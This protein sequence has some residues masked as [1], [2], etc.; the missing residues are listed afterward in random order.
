MGGTEAAGE[1]AFF[2]GKGIEN[3]ELGTGCFVR[4]SIISAGNGVEFVSDR[5]PCIILKVRWCH[6]V[7]NVHAP[8]EDKTNKVL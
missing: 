8:A 3:H 6:I 2:Y 4:K 5:M 7:L 1:Y